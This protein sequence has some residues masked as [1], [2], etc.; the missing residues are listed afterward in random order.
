MDN[1]EMLRGEWQPINW[2]PGHMARAKRRL[3]EQLSRVDVV[4]ELC[5][6]RLP[7]SSRNPELDARL[8]GKTRVLVLNNSDLAQESETNAWLS[9]FKARGVNAVAFSARRSKTKELFA[10]IEES[11]REAVERQA[12]RGIKKT[13]R[14]M[15]VGVPNVGKSTFINRLNGA[16]IAKTG[17]RPGVTRA[18]QWVKVTP[19]LELLDT[20]GMLWP[21]LDDQKAARRL[22]YIG[23]IRDGVVDHQ[24]LAIL[25]LEDMLGVRREEVIE[26][27]HL[28]EPIEPGL[29]LLENACRGRGW[30]LPGAV[31]DTDRGASVVLDEFRAGKLGA[32]TLERAPRRKESAPRPAEKQEAAGPSEEA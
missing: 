16:A 1:S 20:P 12:A 29:A 15:V 6:A 22:Y 24:M 2:Y 14:V 18:N 17:D 8:R 23:S 10:R 28:K 13:V 32:I 31:E 4:V 3:M 7:F 25:L 19:Y 5:D 21:R 11:A 9:Y 30:L 26:R 27:F